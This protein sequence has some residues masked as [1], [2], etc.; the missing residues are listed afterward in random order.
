MRLLVL[1]GLVAVAVGFALLYMVTHG[2][3]AVAVGT[4]G[5]TSKETPGP[6]AV[7][8][9]TPPTEPTRAP[10]APAARHAPTAAPTLAPEAAL[11]SRRR[12]D[13]TKPKH[14]DTPT[15]KLR[16]ALMRAIRA[17]EP[18]VVDCLNQAKTAGTNVDGV[19]SYYFYVKRSGDKI[20]FDGAETEESPYPDPLKSCL[21]DAAKD[22]AVDSMPDDATRVQVLRRLTVEHGDISLYKLGAYHIVAPAP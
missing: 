1:G 16:W 8:A 12:D 14:I 5:G 18:A 20:V 2:S 15:D 4:A 11:D 10:G 21:Q 3:D 9:A 19:S 13:P 6:V 22:V 17:T 7:P